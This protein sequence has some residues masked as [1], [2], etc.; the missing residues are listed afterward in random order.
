MAFTI[1]FISIVFLK[2]IIYENCITDDTADCRYWEFSIV[3]TSSSTIDR[4]GSQ[5][6][7]LYMGPYGEKTKVSKTFTNLQPNK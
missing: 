5:P 1:S 6:K 3:G 7:N 4:C 2:S